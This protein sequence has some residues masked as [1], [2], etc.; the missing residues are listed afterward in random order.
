MQL[1]RNAQIW[2]PGYFNNRLQNWSRPRAKRV[3]VAIT[4][5]YEPFWKNTCEQVA[6]ERVEAWMKG[7]PRVASEC[8]DSTGRRPIY[9]FF[10]PE[11]EYRPHLMDQLTKLV[12]MGIG[13]VEVHLHHDGEGEQ[14][15]VDRMQ[16]FTDT[17]ISRHGLLR[18]LNGRP[19]FGFIHGNWALDNSR[20]DGCRCGLNNELSLL[21][22]LGCYA[23]FTLPSAPHSTQTRM[24][25][26]IYWAV[27]DANRPKSHD[28]GVPFEVGSLANRHPKSALLMIPGPLGIRSSF[29]GNGDRLV[30]R[31][32][33]GEVASYDPP[34]PARIKAWLDLAPRIGDD[35]FVK[36]YTHGTQ[37]RHSSFLLNQ[38]LGQMF[39]WLSSEVK[40]RGQSLYFASAWQLKLAVD[41]I[42]RGEDP[43][44]AVCG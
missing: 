34:T 2:L 39:R 33:T 37:E 26:T 29:L 25:N 24:V 15:F 32:E 4:D 12:R 8:E 9:S 1:P 30:P 36:L 44:A 17:L 16:R 11:E 3:W 42:G 20:A 27:D 22:K 40:S 14:N 28:T 13:D 41:A 21:I 7:W 18:S 43:V 35:V 38:G 6:T 5:H 31:L 10:Y 23:D 19:A